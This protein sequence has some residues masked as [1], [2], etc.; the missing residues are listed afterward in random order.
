MHGIF[1]YI[2][3]IY[4]GH[5]GKYISPMDGMGLERIDGDRHSH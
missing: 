1:T 3:L 5:V 4:M 2:W